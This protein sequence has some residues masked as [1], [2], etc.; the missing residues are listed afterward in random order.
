MISKSI[1]LA[2][3]AALLAAPAIATAQAAD[4]AIGAID[5]LDSAL[6]EAMKSGKT[7]GAEGRYRKLLPAVERAFDLPTMTRFAVG[8]AWAG[9]SA[10]DQAALIKAFGRL[11]AANLAH[12][13]NSYG[14]EQFKINPAVQTRGPDKLVRTQI[15]P[16]KG[17][18]TDLNYRMR[19]SGDSWKVIDVYFG[20]VSQLTAQRSDF[21]STVS[22]GGAAALIKKMNA[23]ADGLLK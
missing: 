2:L 7:T 14:G 22:S 6:I 17:D 15:V 8:S 16:T 19:Q 5:T 9:Y 10:A 20:A 3:L 12:N 4:P 21:A 11:S 23:Q 1:S 18:P 13:F